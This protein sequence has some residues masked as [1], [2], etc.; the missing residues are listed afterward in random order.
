MSLQL[1]FVT[2]PRR[3]LTGLLALTVLLTGTL[4]ARADNLDLQL[5]YWANRLVPAL[6]KKGYKNVGVLH[7][8][9]ERDGSKESFKLG[10]LSDNLATRLENALIIGC[11]PD[12][13]LGVIRD[14]AG[15]HFD[16][17]LVRLFL[18]L[19]AGLLEGQRR[20]DEASFL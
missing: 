7:F 9:V 17:E 15:R 10:S 16:P 13:P 6:E 19:A 1:P 3:W 14:G 4:S 11:N 8:R 2:G 18:P 5:A 12:K 20:E